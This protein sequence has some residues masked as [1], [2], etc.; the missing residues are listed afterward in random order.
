MTLK[1]F[2]KATEGMPED[3][4]MFM[5]IGLMVPFWV[6]VFDVFFDKESNKIKLC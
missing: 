1:E 3:A 5:D 2:Y 6:D 4:E